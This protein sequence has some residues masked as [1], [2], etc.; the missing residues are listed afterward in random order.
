M[1]KNTKSKKITKKQRENKPQKMTKKDA[2]NEKLIK[3]YKIK[4][5]YI[6]IV[7][8]MTQM[9]EKRSLRKRP[10]KTVDNGSVRH[11]GRLRNKPRKCFNEY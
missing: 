4:E 9:K 11:S 2:I 8:V 1:K 7:D 5:C 10:S 3:K 6:R